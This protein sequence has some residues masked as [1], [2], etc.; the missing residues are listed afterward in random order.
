VLFSEKMDDLIATLREQFNESS[1][2][3]N[4]INKNLKVL[5]YDF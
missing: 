1:R 4:E 2:I 3:D 5:G